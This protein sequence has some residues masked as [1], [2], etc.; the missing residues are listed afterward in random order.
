MSL[1]FV[2]CDD[3]DLIITLYS[4]RVGDDQFR[5][6][7][8]KILS[9]AGYRPGM[10]ELVI[11]HPET[12]VHLSVPALA[13]VAELA[14]VYDNDTSCQTAVLVTDPLLAAVALIYSSVASGMDSHEDV[15][16]FDQLAPALEWLERSRDL[17]PSWVDDSLLTASGPTPL[18]PTGLP[19]ENNVATF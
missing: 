18:R 16:V 11:I 19:G 1:D 9:Q 7:Y 6:G 17:L 13:D 10:A 4:D 15:Q 2:L 3:A 5:D 14:R 12:S 8:Q